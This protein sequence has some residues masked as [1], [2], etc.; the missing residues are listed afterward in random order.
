M[1]AAR[2]RVSPRN[3]DRRERRGRATASEE[4]E[5]S[6]R[7]RRDDPEMQTRGDEHVHRSRILEFVA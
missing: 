5:E 1:R 6:V 2:D 3:G 7:H 4:R